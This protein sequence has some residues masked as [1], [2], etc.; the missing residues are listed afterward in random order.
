M[1]L[2]WPCA[3][4]DVSPRVEELYDRALKEN[5]GEGRGVANVMIKLIVFIS[6][7]IILRFDL[8][9]DEAVDRLLNL[10]LLERCTRPSRSPR[11]TGEISF[12]GESLHGRCPCTF[13]GN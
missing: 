6:N 9:V 10:T 1:R 7:I 2:A 3:G 13:I 5:S 4:W 12:S 8:F 11:G